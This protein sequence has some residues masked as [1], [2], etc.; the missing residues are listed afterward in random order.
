MFELYERLSALPFPVFV[1][2]LLIIVALRTQATYWIAR[3]GTELAE[4]GTERSTGFGA[5][6][7]RWLQSSS[8]A[9]GV[10]AVERWGLVIIPLS[11]LTWG[12]QTMVNAGAGVLRLRWSLY[13]LVAFP[14]YV[15]WALV[16]STVG[17]IAIR[18]A[19]AAAA[20]TGEHVLFGVMTIVVAILCAIYVWRKVRARRMVT[21]SATE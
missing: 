3:I 15:A 20:E 19:R 6:V 12:F 8:V 11:F 18:T 1:V 13:T 21:V 14:G 2:T 16:Y 7:H 9:K 10:S 5:K 17:L 4:K